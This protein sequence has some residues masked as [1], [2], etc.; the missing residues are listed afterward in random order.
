MQG[1]WGI[2]S[3]LRKVLGPEV[4]RC[5]VSEVLGI[6]WKSGIRVWKKERFFTPDT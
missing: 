6:V 1:W 2:R 3:D 5:S 4:G